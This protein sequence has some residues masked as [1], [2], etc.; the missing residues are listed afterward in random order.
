M[1]IPVWVRT[2]NMEKAKE[3][4]LIYALVDSQSDIAIFTDQL[5]DKLAG[6]GKDPTLKL[7][8][9][10]TKG[11]FINCQKYSNMKI[12]DYREETTIDISTAST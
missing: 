2:G 3:S 8:T 4:V 11:K 10:T 6:K 12:N 1:I 5:A 7:A 9:M